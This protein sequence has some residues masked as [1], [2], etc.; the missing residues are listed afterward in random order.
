MH[1]LT[2]KNLSEYKGFLEEATL[3]IRQAR[4]RAAQ[5]VNKQI[6]A[7]YWWLG[8][9]IVSHQSEYGWG[10]SVVERL[11]KDLKDAFPDAKFG[12]SPQN[13]WYMRQFYLEYREKPDL[14]QLVG[15]IPWS[16]NLLIMSKVKDDN[17]RL[18][19]L[20]ATR[21]QAWTRNVLR[22]QINSDAYKR[23]QL[24]NKQHNFEATLPKQLAEQAAQSMK[25][26]YMFDMLGIA[27]PVIETEI[28]CRMVE[29]IKDVILEL[30]YGFSFIGN[31]YRIV[32]PDSEYFIDLLFYHRKL[33]ALVALELKRTRFK[34]EHAGKMNFYL[35]LLDEFVKEPHEHASI[36]IILCGEHSRFDVEYALRGI[37]NPVG[38]AGYQLTRDIPEKL[39][40]ALPDAAQLEEKIQFELGL[41][42]IQLN[43]KK[44]N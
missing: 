13:L 11:S 4:T 6:M 42:D 15:E 31:Q 10:K 36:G 37:D 32:T 38:V 17:Q 7:L 24:S 27:E 40:G 12:F 20:T 43:K 8:H 22:E 34:P 1:N 35:N 9:H 2:N 14:Q 19:Y 33:Q 39:K 21:E 23:H 26:I 3:Q 44:G 5:S 30:G 18:Y 29:K 28:E 41:A 25:D 16:Q